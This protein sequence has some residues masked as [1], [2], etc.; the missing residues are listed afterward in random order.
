MAFEELFKVYPCKNAE[1]R[2]VAKVAYEFGM[3][4][5]KEPSAGMSIGLD[6]HAIK[7]QRTYVEVAKGYVEALHNRPV[8]DMP[9]VHP[10]RFD[11]NL[12]E[13]YMQFT[14]D[15]I[16]LNEDTEL[17]A[18]Y[19]AVVAV[20]L[21]ASQSAGLAGS[22]TDADYARAKN[23]I[24]TITQFLDEMETRTAPDVP[25]TAFPGAALEVPTGVKK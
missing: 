7:R 10:T 17:L 19:W 13:P 25:E 3:N 22:L 15:G 5:A 20:E 23:H 1:L 8:P 4:I 18:Q 11:I 16:P 14:K 2:A 12:S 9:Y 6:E 24:D 21:A